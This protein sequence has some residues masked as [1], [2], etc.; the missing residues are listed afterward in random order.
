MIAPIFSSFQTISRR[1]FFGQQFPT[2]VTGVKGLGDDE[3][4]K[5]EG[6]EGGGGKE[7]GKE[8]GKDVTIAGRPTEKEI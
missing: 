5:G 2:G 7:G 8:G 6:D 1:K 4:D 3:G